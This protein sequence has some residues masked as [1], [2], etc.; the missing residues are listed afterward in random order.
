MFQLFHEATAIEFLETLVYHS[1]SCE[2]LG[3]NSI[4]LIDYSTSAVT[5]LLAGSK[6]E[7]SQSENNLSAS[8]DLQKKEM[9]LAFNTG[10]KS[11]SIIACI[12]QNLDR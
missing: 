5:R 6:D 4:D 7:V 8:Q 1:D 9:T 2:A 10:I 3:E 12:A 11:I